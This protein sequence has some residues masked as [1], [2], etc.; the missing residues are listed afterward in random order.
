MRNLPHLGLRGARASVGDDCLSGVRIPIVPPDRLQE[1]RPDVLLVFAW[2]ILP[3]IRAQLEGFPG[4]SMVPIPE[5]RI[6]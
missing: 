2:N 1:D 4:R 5:P 6:L 3:E